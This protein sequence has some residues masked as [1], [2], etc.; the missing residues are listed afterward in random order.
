[1]TQMYRKYNLISH[2]FIFYTQ[3]IKQRIN[4][5]KFVNNWCLTY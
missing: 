4:I 3:H 5:P 1:M 2:I